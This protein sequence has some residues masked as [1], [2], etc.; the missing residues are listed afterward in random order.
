M[1]GAGLV[2]SVVVSLM[3]LLPSSRAASL[4]VV[5]AMDKVWQDVAYQAAEATVAAITKQTGAQLSLFDVPMDTFQVQVGRQHQL[6]I[7]VDGRAYELLINQEAPKQLGSSALPGPQQALPGTAAG[8]Q[9]RQQRHAGGHQ[10]AAHDAVVCMAGTGWERAET[11]SLWCVNMQTKSM[12]W[13][14][15]KGPAR[16]CPHKRALQI[17]SSS[18]Q[19][20]RPTKYASTHTTLPLTRRHSSCQAQP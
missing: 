18:L 6:A 10:V 2:A 5:G 8:Q 14:S 20:Y 12:A 7:E 3:L 4:S 9:V 15:H 11:T 17:S 13:V 16:H 1:G 19:Q